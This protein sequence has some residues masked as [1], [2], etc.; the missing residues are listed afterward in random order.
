MLNLTQLIQPN[1]SIFYDICGFA[2]INYGWKEEELKNTAKYA[3]N[4]TNTIFFG[5]DMFGRN[6]TYGRSWHMLGYWLRYFLKLLELTDVR[7][8]WNKSKN[9]IILQAFLHLVI[10]ENV[11]LHPPT[12]DSKSRKHFNYKL[13]FLI[14]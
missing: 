12:M 2:L 4:G 13:I 6:T 3:K 1:F 8:H 7:M 10:A 14:I 11:N 9:L 5:I